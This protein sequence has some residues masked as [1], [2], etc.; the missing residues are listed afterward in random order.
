MRKLLSRVAICGLATFTAACGGDD[1]SGS[2]T[3]VTVIPAPT[4]TPSPTPTP[5]PTPSPT[6]TPTPTSYASPCDLTRDQAVNLLF[7]A[8][9][10]AKG[11]FTS[12]NDYQ[13]SS[14][15]AAVFDVGTNSLL[16]LDSA[17]RNATLLR[18]GATI[19]SFTGAQRDAPI[20]DDEGVTY[21]AGA[22]GLAF[23]CI[24][25]RLS[26]AYTLTA[27]Y[28][29][30]LP[31]PAPG[32]TD[33]S[34]LILIGGAP[35]VSSGDL[36]SGNYSS[37]AG[38]GVLFTGT[39]SR[40]DATGA[41]TVTTVNFDAPSGV[42]KGTLTGTGDRSYSISFT[43]TV[44][45]GTTRFQGTATTSSGATGKLSGGFFGPGG[46]EFGF[47]LAID[48]GSAHITGVGLGKR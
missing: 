22:N 2:S 13:Y 7:G 14:A 40:Q 21:T 25:T 3:P 4:P 28:G 12:A 17:S 23:G 35:T 31:D 43:A 32:A 37:V 36:S 1:N 39:A 47:V 41:N 46:S 20:A 29:V 42:L 6:P 8:E 18:N 48:D 19:A 33:S 44:V 26:L 34:R 24:P 27:A 38:L 16:R 45:P 10:L 30:N 5:T 15:S 11:A 9:V